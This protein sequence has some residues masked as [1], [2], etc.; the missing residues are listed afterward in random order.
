MT[1]DSFCFCSESKKTQAFPLKNRFFFVVTLPFS[2][3]LT[4]MGSLQVKAKRP[5]TSQT[6]VMSQFTIAAFSAF[7]TALAVAFETWSKGCKLVA[8]LLRNYHIS[9]FWYFCYCC[10]LHFSNTAWM[11]DRTVSLP[12]STEKLWE[13]RFLP[14][15]ALKREF[16]SRTT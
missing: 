10:W 15:R 12:F 5:K 16:S 11:L 14:W 4:A 2:T 7:F 6:L 1:K 3:T 13:F 9:C 8:A